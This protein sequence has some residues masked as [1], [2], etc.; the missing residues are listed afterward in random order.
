M[1][2]TLAAL[3][4]AVA[5]DLDSCTTGSVDSG[6]LT[7]IVDA[8]LIDSEESTT[9]YVGQ[10]LY[11]T[12]GA[13]AGQVRRVSAY[14]PTTG[15]LTVGRAWATAPAAAVT[16][17]LLT[18]LNPVTLNRLINNALLRCYYEDEQLITPVASQRQYS[19][20]AYTWLTRKEQVLDVLWRIGTTASQYH[21][22]PVG[23]YEVRDDS[24]TLTLDIDPYSYTTGEYIVLKAIRPYAELASDAATTLCPLEYAK[25]AAKLEVFTWLAMNGPAEDTARYEKKALDAVATFNSRMRDYAPGRR[26]RVQLGDTP[27]RGV[28]SDVVS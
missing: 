7:A 15:T 27:K 17:E 20:A 1:S 3:R 9:Q 19:L 21:Y 6:S 13:L 2:T 8:D 28:S 10:Y 18:K 25:A 26:W 14:A 12:S 11:L 24:G 22:C 23:W 5:Q 16:Y 4:Q